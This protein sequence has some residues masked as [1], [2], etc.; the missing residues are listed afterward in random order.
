LKEEGE[1]RLYQ[2]YRGKISTKRGEDGTI[3]HTFIGKPIELPIDKA[4]YSNLEKIKKAL[5]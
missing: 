3:R 5:Y 4:M 2:Q 1:K